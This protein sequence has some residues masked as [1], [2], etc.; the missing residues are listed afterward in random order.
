VQ[1]SPPSLRIGIPRSRSIREPTGWDSQIADPEAIHYYGGGLRIARGLAP[2]STHNPGTPLQ[3]LNALIVR[4]EGLGPLDF[5]S[6]LR[7][8][9]ALSLASVILG[10]TI[11]FATA[12]RAAPF[13]LKLT[14]AWSYFLCPKAFERLVVWSPESLYFITGCCLA[15]AV[16]RWAEVPG[17]WSRVALLGAIVGVACAVKFLFAPMAL[18]L[19]LVVPSVGAHERLK[20]SRTALILAVSA[21]LGFVLMVLP[22][23]SQLGAMAGWIW[24]L[25]VHTGKWG[26]GSIGVMAPG[27]VFEGLSTALASSKTWHL[28]V[29]GLLVCGALLALWERRTRQG[30]PWAAA[31]LFA[32]TA[33]V[34]C[35]LLALKAF[36]MR[37]LLVCG[38]GTLVLAAVLAAR[39]GTR[40]PRF[41]LSVVFGFVALGVGRASLNDV[42]SHGAPVTL[43]GYISHPVGALKLFARGD[44]LRTLDTIYPDSGIFDEDTGGVFLPPMAG[45]WVYAVVD[46]TILTARALGVL[47]AAGARPV[48]EWGRLQVLEREEVAVA[49]RPTE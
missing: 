32:G 38:C 4:V 17:S 26:S 5:P 42:R 11:L 37:Y 49:E 36:Q 46:R 21:T 14:V 44:D 23:L 27:S 48:K 13:L 30:T 31:L 2:N 33:S 19:V 3:L 24:R 16:C 9:H 22:A 6:F 29:V 18:A 10:T 40:I 35:Y 45:R 25:S 43:Y 20:A 15:A 8:A 28:W 12:L 1:R 41:V 7:R 47:A 34:G 39:L